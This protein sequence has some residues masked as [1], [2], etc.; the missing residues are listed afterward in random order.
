MKKVLVTYFGPFN[1]FKYN[2]AELIAIELNAIF[3][4][5]SN[6]D[7]KKLDVSFESIDRFLNS[8]L[9]DYEYIIELGVAT[10][11]DKI[12]I[13]SKGTNVINGIDIHTNQKCGTI[14][15]NEEQVIPAR[16]PIFIIDKI[17]SLF[18]TEVVVSDSAGKY[19]CN[20]L[21]FKSL[22]KYPQHKVLFIHIANFQDIITAVPMRQQVRIFETILYLVMEENTC[23]N[24]I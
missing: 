7:F 8:K 13:E 16:F 20:Y 3:K 4:N 5:N 12:R 24:L 18:P 22:F 15:E 2:P 23:T 1:N 10:K 11:S 19:L 14:I 17:I 6:I 21:Y 9:D